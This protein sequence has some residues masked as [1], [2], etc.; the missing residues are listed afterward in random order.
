MA[1]IICEKCGKSTTNLDG[2]FIMEKGKKRKEVCRD[3]SE[4]LQKKGWSIGAQAK[5]LTMPPEV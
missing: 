2:I 4:K 3:C 5:G 1:T